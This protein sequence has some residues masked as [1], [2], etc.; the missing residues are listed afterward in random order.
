[1]KRRSFILSAATLFVQV[2]ARPAP[3]VYVVNLTA[4]KTITF[5]PPPAVP[6]VLRLLQDG[7]TAKTV[8]WPAGMAWRA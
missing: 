4:S 1:M 7:G 8:T 6:I 5:A 2:S 3:F